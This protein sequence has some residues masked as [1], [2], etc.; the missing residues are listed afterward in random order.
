MSTKKSFGKKSASSAKLTT[1]PDLLT[2]AP[3]KLLL[4]TLALVIGQGAAVML[5]GTRDGA[6]LVI[7]LLDGDRRDKVY[8]HDKDELREALTDLAADFSPPF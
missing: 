4:D 5:G 1:A 7:T 3:P 2:S 8:V 6:A